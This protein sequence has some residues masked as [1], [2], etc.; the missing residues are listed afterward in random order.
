MGT[1][2]T[3]L[4][5]MWLFD[6]T[7]YKWTQVEFPST[8]TVPD[9]RSGHSLIPHAEGAVIYGGYCKVKAKKGLQ[10][11]KVLT[12]SW[13]VKMKADPK[14]IR[15]ERRRKQGFTPSPRVGCSM[16]AH[17]NRGILFGGVYDFD[18]SEDNLES[19]F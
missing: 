17:K 3:Y 4:L 19:Q 12:D 10:K 5:D 15:L 6:I 18:E 16:V 7:T 1:L 8:H 11:G 2:T 14:A 9:A 13:L